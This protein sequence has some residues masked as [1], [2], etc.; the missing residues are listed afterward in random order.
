MLLLQPRFELRLELQDAASTDRDNGVVP[1]ILRCKVEGVYG[2]AE[3]GVNGNIPFIGQADKN[4]LCVSP[5]LHAVSI[6][7]NTDLGED[8]FPAPGQHHCRAWTTI[9]KPPIPIHGV[10][11]SRGKAS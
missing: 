1:A 4:V 7:I 6:T 10:P 5:V 8:V 9:S 2:D 3:V 11:R